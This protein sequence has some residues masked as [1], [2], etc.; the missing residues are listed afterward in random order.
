MLQAGELLLEVAHLGLALV[1]VLL[2]ALELLLKG[3]DGRLERG[4]VVPAVAELDLGGHSLRRRDCGGRADGESRR[5]L[6]ARTRTRALQVL[7]EVE[8]AFLVLDERGVGGA[9]LCDL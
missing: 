3:R 5:R 1:A 4:D 6:R 8:Q 7:D 9:L 2:G